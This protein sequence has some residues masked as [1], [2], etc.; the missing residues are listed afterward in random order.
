MQ[1][2]R[3]KFKFAQVKVGGGSHAGQNGL[4]G[5]GGPMHTDSG[6]HHRV[7]HSIDLL[8]GGLLLHCNDH[9]LFPVSGASG[10]RHACAWRRCA[11]LARAFLSDANSFLC[12]ARITSMMRS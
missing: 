10:L 8:F 9:C 4:R 5:A 11:V 7:D 6:F 12:K 2:A 3:Q 1:H